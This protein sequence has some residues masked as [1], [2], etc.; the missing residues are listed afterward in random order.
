[1]S[2]KIGFGHITKLVMAAVLPVLF[3]S[4]AAPAQ[5]TSISAPCRA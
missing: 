2:R 1:M 3:G 5:Q 4:A